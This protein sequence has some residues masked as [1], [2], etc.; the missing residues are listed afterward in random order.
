MNDLPSGT[1]MLWLG[2]AASIPAGWQAYTAANGKFIRGVPVDGTVGATGGAETHTHNTGTISAGGA[3]G[4]PE[5]AII[6]GGTGVSTDHA[7]TGTGYGIYG[8]APHDHDGTIEL[9]SV[10]D[11]EHTN[12][13]TNTGSANQLPPYKKGIFIIKI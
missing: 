1:V 4:H 7:V 5:I 6:H 8:A 13:S 11:H 10:A 3:H 9:Q 12:S 2:S